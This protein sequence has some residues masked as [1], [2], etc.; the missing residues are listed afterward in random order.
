[1]LIFLF[2]AQM[3]PLADSAALLAVFNSWTVLAIYM[4][5]RFTHFVCGV[6]CKRLFP[7]QGTIDMVL[8]AG[9]ILTSVR[10]FS[11]DHWIDEGSW[12][13]QIMAFGI[14]VG[15]AYYVLVVAL[16]WSLPPFTFWGRLWLDF[17][18]FKHDSAWL[19]LEG[20]KHYSA[21]TWSLLLV[22]TVSLCDT[23]VAWLFF[24]RGRTRAMP[25][26]YHAVV[27]LEFSVW[28]GILYLYILPWLSA[29]THPLH[30]IGS[31][32]QMW[33]FC[34]VAASCVITWLIV[35]SDEGCL[36]EESGWCWMVTWLQGVFADGHH[37]CHETAGDPMVLMISVR[38]QVCVWLLL[39]IGAWRISY[40]EVKQIWRA[41]TEV[42]QIWRGWGNY[43][44]VESKIQLVQN[45]TALLVLPAALLMSL[46]QLIEGSQWQDGRV[47]VG[48]FEHCCALALAVCLLL[49]LGIYLLG[50]EW[51]AQYLLMLHKI[52]SE[53][54]ALVTFFFLV[55]CAFSLLLA[56]HMRFDIQATDD[57]DGATSAAQVRDDISKAKNRATHKF[58]D[59][60]SSSFSFLIDPK[61]PNSDH[62]PF[63]GADRRLQIL[64]NFVRAIG[65]SCVPFVLSQ[66]VLATMMSKIGE[67]FKER[68]KASF[69][70]GRSIVLMSIDEEL[71]AQT[72]E[73]T[74]YFPARDP[75]SSE[76]LFKQYDEET[77]YDWEALEFESEEEHKQVVNYAENPQRWKR[78]ESKV[79]FGV[80]RRG[81]G[82]SKGEKWSFD[83]HRMR[84]EGVA[85]GNRCGACG[86]AAAPAD[87]RTRMVE[88]PKKRKLVEFR[89]AWHK[90]GPDA[91]QKISEAL[92]QSRDDEP[93]VCVQLYKKELTDCGQR[94][95]GSS[96][97]EMIE[98]QVDVKAYVMK[99][100]VEPHDQKTYK[101]WNKAPPTEQYLTKAK[102]S[103]TD[104]PYVC[105]I[106]NS[107][108][109]TWGHRREYMD[110]YHQQPS[111][112]PG[113]SG[114]S[115]HHES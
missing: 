95:F 54:V 87:F 84:C 20:F 113:R 66:S 14:A 30:R 9:L 16:R 37:F 36:H 101:L 18:G 90:L 81:P 39:L 99:V 78:G 76:W 24:D 8:L 15:S 104:G 32:D 72:P 42:K 55:N 61:D 92:D 25:P 3:M 67:E 108:A 69:T 107:S 17:E 85:G 103:D 110:E 7:I 86:A 71:L 80:K 40:T 6:G 45:M 58:A 43:M 48:F 74:D 100:G 79:E 109:L 60:V 5:S 46:S 64:L 94:L 1:M 4:T 13:S 12:I 22:C 49:R 38:S 41:Y 91:D 102:S 73:K 112:L 44:Q 33:S 35:M 28:Q 10:K 97:S 65:F 19:E 23:A 31:G 105:D 51:S 53:L 59:V 50:V 34:A 29:M 57:A 62:I 77:C 47:W 27:A 56:L 96:S 52:R 89:R 11:L 115:S 88:R 98:L 26:P 63:A 75:A 82:G 70:M 111:F 21:H 2:R 114:K 106:T 93:I 83:F 68:E